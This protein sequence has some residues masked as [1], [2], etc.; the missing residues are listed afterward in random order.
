[1]DKPSAHQGQTIQTVRRT[2]PDSRPLIAI[3]GP[4]ASGKSL[5]VQALRE[6]GYNAR[7]VA[8]EH[9]YVPDMWQQITQPDTLIYLDVSWE[10]ARQR[11][12]T[13]AGEHWWIEQ[14]HRLRHARQY[15]DLYIRTDDLTP[16]EILDEVL[17]SMRRK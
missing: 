14:A 15:A 3:V 6:R 12:P 16:Q 9:S 17:A 1:M 4:C 7:E 13:D 10:I 5:L 11:R 2:A 8:Q